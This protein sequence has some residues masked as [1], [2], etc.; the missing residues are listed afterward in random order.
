MKCYVAKMQKERDSFHK[1]QL[2]IPE[3]TMQDS[4][5]WVC[6]LCKHHSYNIKW[7]R[8]IDRSLSA[9]PN[10][11]NFGIMLFM[12][13]SLYSVRIRI[14]ISRDWLIGYHVTALSHVHCNLH[15]TRPDTVHAL[16]FEPET[17]G[18]SGST[19][20]HSPVALT[21]R[22]RRFIARMIPSC[23]CRAIAVANVKIY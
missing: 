4:F 9:L 2:S 13:H 20:Y 17:F 5:Q 3:I 16:G 18:I 22:I 10:L 12:P 1:K 11:C 8:V 7:Y 15:H 6:F 23:I 19:S 14:I 21:V